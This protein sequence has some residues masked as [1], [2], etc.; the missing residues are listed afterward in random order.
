MERKQV[1]EQ[2]DEHLSVCKTCDK[3]NFKKWGS[4]SFNRFQKYCNTKC[5]TGK[6]LHKV[7]DALDAEVRA[8]RKQKG[9]SA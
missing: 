9:V 5:P 8:R 3:R 4:P 1:L 7:A 6:K 2:M